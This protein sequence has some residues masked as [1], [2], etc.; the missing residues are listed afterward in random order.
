[1]L[2]AEREAA[3]TAMGFS[4]QAPAR[5]KGKAERY[6]LCV[7]E[8]VVVMGPGCV[9]CCVVVVLLCVV[10]EAQPEINPRATTVRQEAIIFF[11]RGI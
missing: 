3:L 11:I 5:T 4:R 7:S 1:L 8:V 2:Q 6:L 10:S 9:V